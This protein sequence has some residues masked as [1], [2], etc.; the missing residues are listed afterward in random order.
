M[1]ALA[2]LK[3]IQ[4]LPKEIKVMKASFSSKWSN[5]L[6]CTYVKKIF[7]EILFYRKDIKALKELNLI[8]FS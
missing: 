6:R 4:K 3:L 2:M 7:F 8:L 1:H 5:L